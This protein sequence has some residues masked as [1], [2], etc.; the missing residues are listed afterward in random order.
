MIFALSVTMDHSC[1]LAIPAPSRCEQLQSYLSEGRCLP[2]PCRAEGSPVGRF[3]AKA[4]EEAEG[5]ARTVSMPAGYMP[6]AK[7]TWPKRSSP[8]VALEIS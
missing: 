3:A 1:L 8:V 4:E 5:L 6:P 2:R 7:R